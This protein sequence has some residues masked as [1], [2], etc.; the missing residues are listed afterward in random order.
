MRCFSREMFWSGL[1]GHGVSRGD[2]ET[3]GDAELLIGLGL[4]YPGSS[5]L[6][7][8]SAPCAVCPSQRFL[9]PG[10]PRRPQSV[11]VQPPKVS[12]RP[13][14]AW[15]SWGQGIPTTS[16]PAAAPLLSFQPD[17]RG[18]VIE[19]TRGKGCGP[20]R[21]ALCLVRQRGMSGHRRPW[22][23]LV[24]AA[25]ETEATNRC[26]N[27]V[28]KNWTVD[29]GIRWAK[30]ACLKNCHWGDFPGGPVVKNWPCRA[31]DACS[32]PGQGTKI[33]R[34][35]KQLSPAPQ[36]ESML[37]KQRY[38]VQQLRPDPAK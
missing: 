21:K 8:P 10:S 15:A 4:G 16:P 11:A 34:V 29:I 23:F 17:P 19:N 7:H 35:E 18:P 12:L 20:W 30:L 3:G 38:Q 13:P 22:C 6:C 25:R 36:W 31:E 37:C 33:P 1:W 2:G 14:P 9:V 32:I 5:L 28:T 24:Q 27:W 26:A